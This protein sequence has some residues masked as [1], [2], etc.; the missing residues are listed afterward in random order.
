MK[1][2]LELS[3][4]NLDI[5]EFEAV[6][7]LKPK[8]WYRECNLLIMDGVEKHIFERLAY[9]KSAFD[10]L[11]C[12]DIYELEENIAK[13]D[14]NEEVKGPFMIRTVYL[15]RKMFDERYI[16]N[17]VWGDIKNPI[18]NLRTPET[19]LVFF[20][21]NKVYCCRKI[22]ENKEDFRNR[23]AHLRPGKHPV[24]LHPQLARAAV[25][26]S[27]LSQG[28]ICD[29]FCGTGG[30]LI[31]A[32]LMGYK[33]VGYDINQKMIDKAEA[34]LVYFGINDY[35]L[36]IADAIS[37]KGF[38]DAI[39]TDLPY[40]R[41]TTMKGTY[42]SFLK[43]AYKCTERLVVMVPEGTT[44]VIDRWKKLAEFSYYI[45]KSLTKKIVVLR[46]P[47]SK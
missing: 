46:K 20:F 9:T 43:N 24:S 2:L 45:H 18:V 11:F 25:N 27:G 28:T 26:M 5:A 19:V 1:H 40:C 38:Y 41:N 31:E 32:A 16:A 7:T 21:V 17:K 33:I 30:I 35:T 14:W 4:G 34:N 15:G 42:A 36:A 39:V 44:L 47:L 8:T 37:L 22:W 13:T 29:P 3:K 6:E 10:L 23:R 12:C